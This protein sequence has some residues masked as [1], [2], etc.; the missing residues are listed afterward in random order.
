VNIEQRVQ[1]RIMGAPRLYTYGW[2][3]DPLN[4]DLPLGV[5]D[6]VIIPANQ[7]QD[8]ETSA[9]VVKLGSDWTGPVKYIVG[10]VPPA[11]DTDDELWAGFG[12]GDYS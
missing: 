5:G 3:Y 1:V 11:T 6:K 9:T 12:E 7:V 8:E 10:V 4:G 2:N